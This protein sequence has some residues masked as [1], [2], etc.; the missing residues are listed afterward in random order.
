MRTEAYNSVNVS[1]RPLMMVSDIWPNWLDSDNSDTSDI[2]SFVCVS[3]V[4]KSYFI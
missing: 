3:I 2:F 1:N 4:L